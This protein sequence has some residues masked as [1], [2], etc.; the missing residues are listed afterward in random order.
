MDF[1]QRVRQG[2]TLN[3]DSDLRKSVT[4]AV[5]I[6]GRESVFIRVHPWLDYEGSATAPHFHHR[7]HRG[8]GA[9]TGLRDLR[10]LRG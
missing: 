1:D 9:G 3:A 10:V 7:G 8:H 6:P 2:A 4:S 5:E